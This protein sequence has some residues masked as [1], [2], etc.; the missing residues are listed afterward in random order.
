MK[1]LPVLACALAMPPWEVE[2]QAAVPTAAFDDGDLRAGF[3]G[4]L[5][6]RGSAGYDAARRTDNL[7][8]DRRPLVV[9]RCANPE[10]AARALDFAR[11]R[12]L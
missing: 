12:S 10:D 4:E 11:R 1:S 8:F 5:I 3:A 2:G 7:A 9:A 6:G